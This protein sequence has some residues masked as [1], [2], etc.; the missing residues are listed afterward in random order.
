M[1]NV[2]ESVLG[3]STPDT[4]TNDAVES[5]N[6]T[7]QLGDEYNLDIPDDT[8]DQNDVTGAEDDTQD[9]L[10]T[11]QEM[12]PTNQ[13]FA[14]M[15]T[16]NK[17][18]LSKINELDAIAKAAG[19]QG[20]D[21]LIAKSKEAQIRETAKSQGIPEEVARQLAEFREF[22]EQYAQDKEA[23]A[24]QAKEQTLVNNLQSFIETNKLSK[25]AVNKMSD[26]LAKD[27]FT[28][29]RLMD[30]PKSALNR[31]LS[32]YVGADVQK[33][34]ERKEAIRN[35]LPLNQSSKVDMNNINKQIDDLAK[36]FAGKM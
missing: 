25:E 21:D 29:D 26:D 35:E 4:Q 17:E 10:F 16:Q 20:V 1:E 28:T 7:S 30:Y 9:D 36:Q 23:A 14:Q 6:N 11:E 8:T 12:N 24:Y 3:T 31:I 22:K 18:Y 2:F 13:A 15:R 33:T 5:T 34:L 32:S 27:G 19:L